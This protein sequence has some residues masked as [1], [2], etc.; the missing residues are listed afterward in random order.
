MTTLDLYPFLPLPDLINQIEAHFELDLKSFDNVYGKGATKP[1]SFNVIF[2]PRNLEEHPYAP[3]LKAC[4][5][6]VTEGGAR[7]GDPVCNS[8]GAWMYQVDYSLKGYF[9]ALKTIPD[10]RLYRDRLTHLIS[11]LEKTEE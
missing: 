11:C 9:S 7:N 5:S 8:E 1:R 3:Q 10:A 2:N 6:L 4:F